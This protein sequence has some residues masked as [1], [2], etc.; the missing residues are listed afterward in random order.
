MQIETRQTFQNYHT[1]LKIAIR[2][3]PKEKILN[4]KDKA[5]IIANPKSTSPLV[6]KISI[7]YPTDKKATKLTI[8]VI[9]FLLPKYLPLSFSGTK[10]PIQENQGGCAIPPKMANIV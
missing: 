4:V 10:S 2:K 9:L 7:K 1:F 3:S 6:L 8:P 5:K